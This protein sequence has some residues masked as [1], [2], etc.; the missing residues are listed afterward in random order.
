M[1]QRG[2]HTIVKFDNSGGTLTDI[3]THVTEGGN[4][5]LNF[6]ELE[7]SGYGDDKQYLKGQGDTEVTLKI[8]F[9]STTHAIFTH[10]STGCLLS[11]AARTL[12]IQFGNQAAPTTGDPKISGEFICTGIDFENAKDGVRMMNVKLRVPVGQALPAWGA[13]S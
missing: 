1:S 6:D 11:D 12:E 4:V 9:N 10:A 8:K 2:K 3:S 7:A 13:V 5:P